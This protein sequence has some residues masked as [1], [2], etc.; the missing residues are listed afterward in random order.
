[1][2]IS[3][4]TAFTVAPS[5]A[6]RSP[7]RDARAASLLAGRR[8]VRFWKKGEV[9][10]QANTVNTVEHDPDHP[11]SGYQSADWC[12]LSFTPLSSLRRREGH[13]LSATGEGEALRAEG[14]YHDS[15]DKR[16][17]NL[18]LS[19]PFDDEVRP[20]SSTRVRGGNEGLH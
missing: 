3:C 9:V 16:F 2:L 5:Q 17:G 7:P 15:L 12:R 13:H 6:H 20:G 8:Q 14:A 4:R 10:E 18:S 1:M 11:I 19:R